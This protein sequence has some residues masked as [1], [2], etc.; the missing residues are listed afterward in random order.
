MTFEIRFKHA[1]FENVPLDPIGEFNLGHLMLKANWSRLHQKRG[2]DIRHLLIGQ[3]VSFSLLA[4]TQPVVFSTGNLHMN[5]ARV[6]SAPL[7]IYMD[8]LWTCFYNTSYSCFCLLAMPLGLW[9]SPFFFLLLLFVPC[10]NR[11]LCLFSE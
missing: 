1:P 11:A 9:F 2:F 10:G 3:M 8:M 6:N 7:R 4:C 5:L